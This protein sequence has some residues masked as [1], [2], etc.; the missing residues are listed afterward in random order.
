MTW[1]KAN[2]DGMDFL[3]DRDFAL[4]LNLENELN[5]APPQVKMAMS[6]K[7]PM[8][9]FHLSF[10]VA[11]SHKKVVENRERICGAYGEKLSDCVVAEQAHRSEV[12]IVANEDRGKGAFSSETAIPGCDALITNVPKLNLCITVADCLPVYF[13]DPVNQAIGLA[14]SGWGGTAGRI[15]QKT[16]NAMQVAFGTHSKNCRVAIGPGI[17]GEGY[18]VDDRVRDAFPEPEKSSNGF[19]QSSPGHW[20]LDLTQIVLE[21][22]LTS[23]IPTENISFSP[24]R[25]DTHPEMLYSHRRENGCP[26]MLALL[27]LN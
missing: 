5:P 24:W 19:R 16:L 15:A 13:F 4:P 1:S 14:H 6:V 25:T 10:N 20:K 8:P 11:P 26:R 22:L 17:G 12:A 3:L 2:F 18:E 23:G 9:D 21:Q 27:K 7:Q